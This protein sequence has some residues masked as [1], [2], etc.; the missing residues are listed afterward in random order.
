MSC[1]FVKLRPLAEGLPASGNIAWGAGGACAALRQLVYPR[2]PCPLMLDR[3]EPDA[4]IFV[5]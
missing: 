2:I 1:D 3:R 4:D 5:P